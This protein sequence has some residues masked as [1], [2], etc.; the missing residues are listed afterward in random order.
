MDDAMHAVHPRVVLVYYVINDACDAPGTVDD[1]GPSK[2]TL[3]LTTPPHQSLAPVVY[4][5]WTLQGQQLASHPFSTL[6]PYL[7]P[8]DSMQTSLRD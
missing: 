7:L 5:W 3:F 1:R 4:R 8:G 6:T 2:P